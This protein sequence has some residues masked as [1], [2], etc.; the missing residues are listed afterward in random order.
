MGF[1]RTKLFKRLESSGIALIQS[2]ERHILRNF[3]YLYAIEQ[4]LDI[5]IGTQDADL[6]DT[7]NNDEDSD[8][9]AATLFDAETE[10]E[11]DTALDLE[12]QLLQTEKSF[13]GRAEA[14]YKEY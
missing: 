2:L 14:V 10:D 8:S 12:D 5:P 11:A 6:L 1:S 13:R 9:V 4:G 7:R 3:I